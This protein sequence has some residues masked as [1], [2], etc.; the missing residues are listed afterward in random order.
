MTWALLLSSKVSRREELIDELAGSKYGQAVLRVVSIDPSVARSFDDAKGALRIGTS[1]SNEPHYFLIIGGEIAQKMHKAEIQKLID[2]S[3]RQN[4]LIVMGLADNEIERLALD[5]LDI[6]WII[7][8]GAP[9]AE[10]LSQ[11]QSAKEAL[12]ASFEVRENADVGV[13]EVN[14]H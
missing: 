8:R 9:G 13:S 7:R 6:H 10:F 2:V 5:E 4:M 11:F 12:I 1:E 14:L 3:L